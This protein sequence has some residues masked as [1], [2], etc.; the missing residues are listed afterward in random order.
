METWGRTLW[1]SVWGCGGP[2]GVVVLRDVGPQRCAGLQR[3]MGLQQCRGSAR[4]HMELQRCLW[5]YKGTSGAAMLHAGVCTGTC[6]VA[7][8]HADLQ[9]CAWRVAMA[10]VALQWCP[11]RVAV[12]HMGMQGNMW[13]CNRA[14]R[15]L[16]RCI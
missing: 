6:E 2:R 10:R 7:R 15:G 9:Q 8:G 12:V 5:A 14:C 1:D 11:W 13:G 16:Q 4:G 3:R